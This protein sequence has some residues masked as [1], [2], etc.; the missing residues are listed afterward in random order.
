METKAPLTSESSTNAAHMDHNIRRI[1]QVRGPWDHSFWTWSLSVHCASTR[2]AVQAFNARCHLGFVLFCS[3]GVTDI[4]SMANSP[5]IWSNYTVTLIKKTML[6]CPHAS[7]GN[8]DVFH[9]LPCYSK[10]H[11][12]LFPWL[13]APF[14]VALHVS[15]L[16]TNFLS[17]DLPSQLISGTWYNKSV[18]L[19]PL[20][21]LTCI[22]GGP[23]CARHI[24]RRRR[25]ENL[26]HFCP[27]MG[28]RQ[29]TYTVRAPFLI[30][31]M[32]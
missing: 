18:L 6:E 25:Y 19:L 27:Q 12:C 2:M 20:V 8:V 30:V 22:V 7:R 4:V 9:E 21:A 3:V 17:P 11:L 24:T 29:S 13:T 32:C 1:Y 10:R 15:V 26:H 14:L 16:N 31:S 28:Q 23:I 5:W